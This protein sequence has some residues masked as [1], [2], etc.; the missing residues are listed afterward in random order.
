MSRFKNRGLW[1]MGVMRDEMESF[2]GN[3]MVNM[4]VCVRRGFIDGGLEYGEL[5]H[6]VF[7]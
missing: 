4:C 6:M 2:M 3:G 5:A 7:L 1:G